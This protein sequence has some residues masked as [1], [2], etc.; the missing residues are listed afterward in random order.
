MEQ[1]AHFAR[2]DRT[3]LLVQ[4]GSGSDKNAE[5]VN[6]WASKEEEAP[7]GILTID[8]EQSVVYNRKLK[9]ATLRG[10]REDL[11][12]PLR[13]VTII[14]MIHGDLTIAGFETLMDRDYAQSWFC[15]LA[16]REFQCRGKPDDDV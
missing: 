7:V 6:A 15:R 9:L 5:Q 10:E 1:T 8:V 3:A 2:N 16:T 14:R 12:P 13:D 4:V 11:L